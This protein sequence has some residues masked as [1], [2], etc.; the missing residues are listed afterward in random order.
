MRYGMLMHLLYKKVYYTSFFEILQV[1]KIL[2]HYRCTL[3]NHK[4]I[5]EF[6][7]HTN[8]CNKSSHCKD[9]EH[10]RYDTNNLCCS[11]VSLERKISIIMRRNR[12]TKTKHWKKQKLIIKYMYHQYSC[13]ACWSFTVVKKFHILFSSQISRAS[14]VLHARWTRSSRDGRFLWEFSFRIMNLRFDFVFENRLYRS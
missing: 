4:N 8:C 2:K 14:E 1:F 11:I 9:A 5:L 13:F 6:S 12:L 7:C 3:K 10:D